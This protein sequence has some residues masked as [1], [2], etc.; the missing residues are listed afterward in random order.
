[1]AVGPYAGFASPLLQKAPNPGKRFVDNSKVSDHHAIIPTEQPLKLQALN[2]DEKNLYD[3]IARRFI[4]VLYPPYRFDQTMITTVINGENFYSKGR[5]VKDSG[6]RKV[7]FKAVEKDD[8]DD[9][10][11][12]TLSAQ[13]KG[14]VK[15]VKSVK[16]NKSKTKPPSRYTEATLLT[17]MESPGK[18]IEDEELRESIKAGGLGTPATRA[19]IIEKLIYANYIERHGKELVPTSKGIQLIGLV[20]PDL[21]SPELTAQW[22]LRLSE[23]AKGTGNRKEFMEGIRQNA[24]D[25]VEDVSTDTSTFKAD[26]VTKTKCP[27]CG[28]YMLL[29]N[30]RR[31]KMLACPD[32][33]C[34]YRQ[35][36]NEDDSNIYKTSKQESYRNKKL[37]SKF[38]NTESVGNSLGDLLKAALSE[39]DDK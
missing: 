11:E 39:K 29:I 9:L 14:S 13:Q 24:A 28:K 38:S 2:N 31:G 15:A 19:E 18:F 35:N 34:G 37:I 6:W 17:A 7:E 32:R 5:V 36:A 22:E 4:S 30:S 25:L 26:N 12:Q 23:I 33:E 21:K 8:S 27:M 20:P 3:L 16:A 1:M 10:P